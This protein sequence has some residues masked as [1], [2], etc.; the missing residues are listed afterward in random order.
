M[1]KTRSRPFLS[2]SSLQILATKCT[3]TSDLASVSKSTTTWHEYWTTLIRT[4]E[5]RSFRFS[6]YFAE[7]QLLVTVPAGASS[8]STRP[9]RSFIKTMR[10]VACMSV[11]EVSSLHM[12][13]NYFALCFFLF[14]HEQREANHE[15][16]GGARLQAQVKH[17]CKVCVWKVWLRPPSATPTHTSTYRPR[18]LVAEEEE[19]FSWGPVRG[20]PWV[21][22]SFSKVSTAFN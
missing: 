6:F 1:S 20:F 15:W 13:I 18:Q 17:A 14:C 22:I 11:S 3:L 12:I 8:S 21:F 16:L 5:Q 4:F 10:T 2:L 7:V 9:G 19:K